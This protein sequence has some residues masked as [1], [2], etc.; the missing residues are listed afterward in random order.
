MCAMRLLLTLLLLFPLALHAAD[1][2]DIYWIDVEGGA[3]TLIV[4]PGGDTVLMDAGWPGYENRDAKRI[5]HVLTR[6]AKAE[7]IDYF[8]TSHFHGDHVGGVPQLVDLVPVEKFVEHG[9]SV[10]L[11]RERGKK[12]WDAYLG[13]AHE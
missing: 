12:L 4:T 6:E 11:G 2:L 13:V 8:I 1:T 10:E 5:Q 3:A 7:K 9:E